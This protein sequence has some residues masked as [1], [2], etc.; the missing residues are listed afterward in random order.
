MTYM[1]IWEF[2]NYRDYIQSQLGFEG[3]RTGRRK[4]L[5][6]AI[7]VHTTYVSQVLHGKADF[8]LEQ[9]EAI[10]HFFQHTEDE[11]DYLLL[12]ISKDRAGSTALRKRYEHKIQKM[13]EERQTI[14][15]RLKADHKISDKDR[16]KFY[17]S[18]YYGATHVL[19]SL[20]GYQN[21]K[22]LSQALNL[23]LNQT[24]Q[25]VDFLVS[26]GLL[27]LQQHKIVP[28]HHHIHL[29]NDSELILKH[30]SN[31][32]MHALSKL[33]F[34]KKDDLH[35]SSAISISEQGAFRVKELLLEVLKKTVQEVQSHPP[36]EAYVLNFD[37]YK[38][39][40]S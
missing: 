16:E 22:D 26:I 33:Q 21:L 20:P 6:L 4:E 2:T 15:K 3:Q 36:E 37:F 12:L 23:P 30:H 9:G 31:W 25:I 11:G 10:N 7:Q 19:C 32:R 18:A 5:A 40:N 8:S 24:S 14:S 13:R 1:A 17:S 34:L 39:G 28:G 29:G 27:E 35:Y 38:M